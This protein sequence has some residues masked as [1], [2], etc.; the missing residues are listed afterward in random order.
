MKLSRDLSHRHAVA[1][2]LLVLV[3]IAGVFA[4]KPTDL[5]AEGENQV[6]GYVYIWDGKTFYPAPNAEVLAIVGKDVIGTAKTNDKGQYVL[7]KLK[8]EGPFMLVCNSS[9]TGTIQGKVFCAPHGKAIQ[10]RVDLVLLKE[11]LVDQFTTSKTKAFFS[12]IDLR[13]FK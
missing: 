12:N 3:S 4:V 10:S 7:D 11:G 8:Q 6:T 2:L 9:D 5:S 13:D 1:I